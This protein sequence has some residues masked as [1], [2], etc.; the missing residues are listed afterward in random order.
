M[1]TKIRPIPEGA[2]LGWTVE[3]NGARLQDARYV[4]VAHPRLG[5]LNFGQRPEGTQGWAWNEAGGG[6][7]VTIPYVV[8][9]GR[10]YVG[11]VYEERLLAGGFVWNVPRAFLDP[12]ETHFQTAIRDT[13]QEEM[14][15]SP[16]EGRISP[17]LG[18]AASWNSTFLETWEEGKGVQYFALEV[19]PQELREEGGGYIFSEAL[20]PRSRA[21]ERILA[22]R[23]HPWWMAGRVGDNFSGKAFARL[24]D[25]KRNL[26]ACLK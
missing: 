19:L 12:G 8:F 3:I 7:S 21:G 24:V 23:F 9:N 10:L 6:G 16:P 4:R 13:V 18:E 1:T 26:I 11:M 5:E 14:G 17:L 2:E 22:C 20:T 15:Y 25:T